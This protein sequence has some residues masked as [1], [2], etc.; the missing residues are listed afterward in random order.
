MKTMLTIFSDKG[1]VLTNGVIF[2]TTISLAEGESADEFYEIT[3]E[4]YEEILKA[5]EEKNN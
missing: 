3:Q 2:G 1:K 5:E 4:K